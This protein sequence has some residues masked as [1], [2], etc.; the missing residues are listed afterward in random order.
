[1]EVT[2]Q[3]RTGTTQR[4]VS[5]VRFVSILQCHLGSTFSFSGRRILEAYLHLLLS[6]SSA[7]HPKHDLGDIVARTLNSYTLG[8]RVGSVWG[9]GRVMRW[10][11]TIAADK[12]KSGEDNRELLKSVGLYKVQ[13]DAVFAVMG[14]ISYQ[15]VRRFLC[16]SSLACSS[17]THF[18]SVM[19]S[20]LPTYPVVSLY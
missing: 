11:P 12:L 13:G 10:T 9:L 2:R 15:F 20:S 17:P 1:M 8:E 3:R 18:R 16:L 7:L 14:G 6:S 5:W 19:H 4:T